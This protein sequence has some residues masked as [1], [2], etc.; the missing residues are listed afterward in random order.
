M[1]TLSG[2]GAGFNAG[3]RANP[4]VFAATKVSA[5]TA[6]LR[7]SIDVMSSPTRGADDAVEQ[8]QRFLAMPGL[9]GRHVDRRWRLHDIC[10]RACYGVLSFG[11]WLIAAGGSVVIA[12]AI[13]QLASRTTRSGRM[14]I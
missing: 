7:L 6:N 13:G 9:L 12:R 4:V 3:G 5:S 2:Q 8:D 10:V 1:A 11:G 14:Q